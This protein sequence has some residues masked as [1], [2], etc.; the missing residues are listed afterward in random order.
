MSTVETEL[1][2]KFRKRFYFNEDLL[3]PLLDLD[4]TQ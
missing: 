3:M 1:A 4:L 2:W